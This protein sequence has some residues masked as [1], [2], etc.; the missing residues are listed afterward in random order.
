MRRLVLGITL[1]LSIAVFVPEV[2]AQ[3]MIEQGKVVL[4]VNPGETVV[5]T[6]TIDNTSKTTPIT[7]RVYW[8]DFMYIAP[9]DG[10][11]EFNPAGTSERSLNN[12]ITFSPQQFTIEPLGSK[13]VS[14]SLQ[15]PATA[16]GGYYGVLFLENAEAKNTNKIGMTVVTRLGALFFVETTNSSRKAVVA[17]RKYADKNFQAEFTNL[18]DVVLIPDATYYFLDK[19]GLVAQRGEIKKFYLAAQKKA[20]FKVPVDEKLAAG[21]YTAI[22]TF[23]FGDNESF[24]D[25]FDFIKADNGT[26][27][28]V[29]KP[30]K[31]AAE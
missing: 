27:T 8:N 30:E 31:S 26:I 10:T 28:I 15:V 5:D 24:T 25:E 22:L 9:F 21:Q 23:D 2:L 3:V 12:W 4:K 7:L 18:G 6:I 16:K 13:K 11:K 17:N 29:P 20:N 19:N 14:Y 1:F